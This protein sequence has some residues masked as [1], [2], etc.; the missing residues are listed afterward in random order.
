MIHH[1]RKM[2]EAPDEVGD[3]NAML[4]QHIKWVAYS[5]VAYLIVG[6][7]IMGN[8]LS[9][10]VLTRPNLKGV[11]YVYLLGSLKPLCTYH[12]SSCSL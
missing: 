11:M 12:R 2:S 5:L 10:V 3:P 9:L 8:L 1:Q 4:V 6:V 7:G